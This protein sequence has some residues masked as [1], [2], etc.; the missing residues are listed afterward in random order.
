[1]KKG[2]ICKIKT[3]LSRNFVY[4]LQTFREFC[5]VHFTILLQIQPENNFP[6]YQ[7]TRANQ[8]SSL[9]WNLFLM[10]AS[11]IAQILSFENVS[12]QDA[13]LAPGAKQWIAKE[14]PELREPIKNAR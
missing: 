4:N 2:T 3:S 9:S 13:I 14:Y 5:Q 6:T 10:T 1:M 8:S 11:F 7:W 12:K